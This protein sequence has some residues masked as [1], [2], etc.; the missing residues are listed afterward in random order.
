M[1]PDVVA[2]KHIQSTRKG[3]ILNG[4]QT[5]AVFLV[6]YLNEAYPKQFD[7]EAEYFFVDIYITSDSLELDK[8]GLMNPLYSIR[9]DGIEP[10]S[11]RRLNR[12]DVAHYG[13]VNISPWGGYFLVTFPTQQQKNKQPLTLTLFKKGLKESNLI[14]DVTKNNTL[15]SL[16][17]L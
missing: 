16:R 10:I 15:K 7:K 17:G 3:E 2:E 8:R 5:E 1:Q 6:T 14:F 11:I 13:F 12:D 4:L 9:L